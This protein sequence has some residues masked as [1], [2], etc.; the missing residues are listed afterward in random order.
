[1]L[2]SLRALVPV[3][4][5]LALTGCLTVTHKVT[6]FHNV[7]KPETFSIRPAPSVAGNP[8]ANA[9][10]DLIAQKLI[11][12]G[13]SKSDK[14]AVDVQFDYGLDDSQNFG[15]IGTANYHHWVYTRKLTVRI[16]E[17]ATKKRIY[18]GTSRNGG[19][20][21]RFDPVV[22]CLV[23]A[24]FKDFPGESGQTNI[25]NVSSGCYDDKSKR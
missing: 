5:C 25:V 4:M 7:T 12:K 21:S 15:A 2:L 10:G 22:H 13:W 11:E 17:K 20:S 23:N 6:V 1:M 19:V 16:D 3:V 8:E 18:E 9:Y 14:P 24:L